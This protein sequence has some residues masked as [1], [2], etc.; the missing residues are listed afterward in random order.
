MQLIQTARGNIC[1][2][3]EQCNVLY[4]V[5]PFDEDLYQECINDAIRRGYPVDGNPSVRT[6]LREGVVYA[7]TAGV[8]LPHRPTQ[9][10]IA[11]YTSCAIFVDD[12]VNSFLEEMPNI[13][14]FNERFIRN[15]PQGN[16]VLDAFADIMRRASE[17]YHPVASHL[18]T[19]STLNFVTANLLEHET[20]SMKI[21][22]AAHQY[23]TYQRT[24]SGV[25]EAYAFMVFPREVPLNDY[26]QA[27]PEMTQ[28]IHN[29]NDVLSFYKEERVGETTN[30][31]S[32]LAARTKKSKL[33]AF[34]ELTETT[35]GLFKRIVKIL[36][37]SP[38]ACE[39]FKHYTAGY[40]R[41]HTSIVRYQL[42]DLDL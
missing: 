40:V 37:G 22:S 32:T 38:R 36:E 21:S 9:T 17:L 30:Q 2:L 5:T 19:T 1:S 42:E 29:T 23:P 41:F 20:R 15:E 31:I 26:I 27:I 39:A 10:W 12:A 13:Y 4:E 24:M 14:L 35:I 28:F 25:A 8:H 18:I 7:A 16:G 33:E 11:L 34:G 3:L 6:Y